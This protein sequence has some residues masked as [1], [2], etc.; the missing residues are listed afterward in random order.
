MKRC[1]KCGVELALD[2]FYAHPAMAD[3]RLGKCKACTRTDVTANRAAKLD[4]YRAYDV[5]R[6]KT[7]AVRQ[8]IQFGAEV[9]RQALPHRSRARGILAKAVGAGTVVKPKSCQ[10]CGREARIHGHH[11]DYWTPLV[12]DWLCAA[13][14]WHANR[15]VLGR[16]PCES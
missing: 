2:Q 12:V 9:E 14:H 1:F 11:R 16:P 3:G 4:Y 5:A 8:R 7:P 6:A 10:S 13:C 15:D